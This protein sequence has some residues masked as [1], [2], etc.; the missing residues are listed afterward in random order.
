[1]CIYICDICVYIHILINLHLSSAQPSRTPFLLLQKLMIQ[2]IKHGL[3][4]KPDLYENANP[5][6]DAH[7]REKGRPDMR[8][9]PSTKHSI[10]KNRKLWVDQSSFLLSRTLLLL[11]QK[12][13]IQW[14]KHGLIFKPDLCEN[15]NPSMDAHWRKRKAWYA[16]WSKQQA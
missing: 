6:M 1:M 3:I 11:L 7:W 15:A 16:F 14:I 8:S 4:F 9:D 13:M 5:S 2:R 12:L 10:T